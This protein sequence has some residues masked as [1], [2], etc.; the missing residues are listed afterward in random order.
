MNNAGFKPRTI[1]AYI[2]IILKDYVKIKI[3]DKDKRK[4]ARLC[5]LNIV[6]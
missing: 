5:L 3:L 1:V 6:M 4:I 2:R